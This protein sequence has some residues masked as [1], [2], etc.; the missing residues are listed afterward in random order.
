MKIIHFTNLVMYLLCISIWALPLN[1]VFNY[2]IENLSEYSLIS[3]IALGI[4]QPF[5][6]LIS[7]FL[8]NSRHKSEKRLLIIYWL[9][10]LIYFSALALLISFFNSYGIEAFVIFPSIIASYFVYVTYKTQLIN[11]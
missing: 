10:V 1:Y 5:M 7:L 3:M 8:I 6:A 2:P 9:L 4:G 11:S